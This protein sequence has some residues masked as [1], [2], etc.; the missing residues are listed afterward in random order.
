MFKRF[1]I[2]LSVLIFLTGCN[3]PTQEDVIDQIPDDEKSAS[4]ETGSDDEQIAEGRCPDPGIPAAL[5]FGHHVEQNYM[6][7]NMTSDAQGSVPITIG[8][9]G[10]NGNGTFSMKLSGSFPRG[11]CTMSGTN[12]ANVDVNGSCKNGQLELMLTETYAGGSMTM[13]CPDGSMQSP[14]PGTTTTHEIT[15]PLTH[16]HTVTAPFVGEAGSGNYNW[17]LDLLLDDDLS[18][19][20]IEPV[21]LVPEDSGDDIEPV[22]IVPAD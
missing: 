17:T 1:V 4:G 3:A 16:G 9:K 7:N 2:L 21:P 6:G 18:G 15:M 20:D 11:G 22:P 8:T 14:I 19:D 10:V 5:H 12:S 13:T